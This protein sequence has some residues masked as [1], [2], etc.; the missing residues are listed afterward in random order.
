M[1]NENEARQFLQDLNQKFTIEL[2]NNG[3]LPFLGIQLINKSPNIETK[4]YVKPTS[5]GPLLLY[6]SHVDSRYKSS[7]ITTMLQLA[8]RISSSWQHFTDEC[9]RLEIM[10]CKLKYPQHMVKT[11]IRRF[12]SSRIT[13]QSTNDENLVKVVVPFKDQRF[14]D[15]VR[16]RL[17]DLSRKTPVTIQPGFCE[18]ENQRPTKDPWKE[19]VHR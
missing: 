3:V 2:E 5:T 11:T 6:Q 14:A 7:L 8:W 13:A 16:N 15:I 18:P 17:K 10:F 1:P 9:E 19:T 4:V 12:T